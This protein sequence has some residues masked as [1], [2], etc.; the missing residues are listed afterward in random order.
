[1]GNHCASC[2]HRHTNRC[3]TLIQNPKINCVNCNHSHHY[4]ATC[5]GK[6]TLYK[7]EYDERTEEVA[8]TVVDSYKTETRYEPIY[9]Q[10]RKV[11]SVYKKVPVQ[12]QVP[13]Y[14]KYDVT[15]WNGT[16]HV[17]LGSET[18]FSHHEYRTDYEYK[19]CDE[20][21]WEKV[22]VGA[23]PIQTQVPDKTHIEYDEVI[24]K[25]PRKVPYTAPCNCTQC[26]C[27]T[28]CPTVQCD[29][30]RNRESC[31]DCETMCA[32]CTDCL[33]NC[34]FGRLCG[35]I[36]CLIIGIPVLL[37]LLLLLF[38]IGWP[39]LSIILNVSN[40]SNNS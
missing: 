9:E 28:C 2:N 34:D 26:N 38:C 37:C 31:Y 17:Y 5:S 13:I 21:S 39:I 20:E 6:M 35:I 19:Y 22:Q 10:R 16:R 14:K 8:R 23:K 7:T 33:N 12:K 18:K 15:R 29:C 24:K 25:V 30:G 1:M 27:Q 3:D 32:P 11:A 40:A 4:G 36:C